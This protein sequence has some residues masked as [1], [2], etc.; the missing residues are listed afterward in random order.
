VLMWKPPSSPPSL[1]WERE[2]TAFPCGW[3]CGEVAAITPLGLFTSWQ[4]VRVSDTEHEGRQYFI[5][6]QGWNAKY[7]KWV[8]CSVLL[9]VGGALRRLVYPS[10][11]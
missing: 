1:R 5:H 9:K 6:Y 4:V 11:R 7:D 10:E 8:P 2:K 3:H